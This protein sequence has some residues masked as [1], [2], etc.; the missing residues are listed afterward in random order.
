MPRVL[1][2]AFLRPL[3]IS[4]LLVISLAI[5]SRSL[6]PCWAVVLVWLLGLPLVNLAFPNSSL[7]VKLSIAPAL[8]I[9]ILAIVFHLFSLLGIGIT[10]GTVFLVVLTFVLLVISW[11]ELS[12]LLK[13]LP[14]ERDDLLKWGVPILVM[15]MI[16]WAVYT[17]PTDN[18]DNFFHATKIEYMLRY[19]TTYPKVVPIFDILTYPA[20]YHSLA[21]FIMLLSGERVIPKVMLE[22]RLWEWVFLAM[23]LYVFSHTWFGRK[24]ANYTLL[25]MLGVNILHYYLLVYIAPNFLGFYFFAVL[26][27]IFIEVYKRPD[28][29]K[30]PLLV[31]TSVGAILV[32][33]YSYQNYVFV[34]AVYLGLKLL[35]DGLSTRNLAS[36]LKH[37]ITFFAV[38]LF[39]HALVDPYFWFPSLAHVKIEYSQTPHVWAAVPKLYLFRGRW[40]RDTWWYFE[41]FTK[42]ATVR[43]DNYLGTVFTV[44]GGIFLLYK[45][46]YRRKGASLVVFSAFVFLL[47]LDRLTI[48]ISVPFYSTAAIERMFLWLVPVLPV[49][50]GAGLLWFRELVFGL[51]VREVSKRLFYLSVVGAFFLVP[52]IGTAYDLLSAEA[53]FYVRADNIDDF[54]W[55]STR[56][57]NATVLNSCTL[58]SAQWMPFFEPSSGVKVMFNSKIRRCR[59]GNITPSIFLERLLN[60]SAVLPGYI[61]YIDTNAPSLNPLELFREYKLLRTNGNNWVFDLSSKDT[62]TN[63]RKAAAALRVCSDLIPGNTERYGRYF[64]YGFG[65]KYFGI[66]RMYLEGLDYAWMKGRKG[67]IGFAPCREYG[68]FVIDLYSPQSQSLNVTVNG[69][70]VGEFKLDAGENRLNIPAELQKGR[71]VFLSMS[72]EKGPLFVRFIKLLPRS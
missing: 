4:S 54:H 61:A 65:K 28:K 58:D 17:Y 29:R 57:P 2:R 38:P 63:E 46:E 55:I 56:F 6:C 52:A 45:R 70:L 36:F 5:L 21:S 34:A 67:V 64:V 10:V 32:H 43:N 41:F 50:A 13:T 37:A 47:I 60:E 18:V 23:G 31:L 51:P 62:S 33:P 24:V 20:G 42:W 9:S 8:G 40:S 69:K 3:A 12:G 44:L 22:L 19:D 11:Q 16:H 7:A 14:R 49:F 26:L 27:A 59:I 72:S 15:V 35:S 68:G 53:N 66:R 48:N 1:E 30:Y 71:V 39:V 25:V